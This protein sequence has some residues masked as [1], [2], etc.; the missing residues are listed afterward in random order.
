MDDIANLLKNKKLMITIAAGVGFILVIWIFFYFPARKK[1]QDFKQELQ[2]ITEEIRAIESIDGI[3]HRSVAE[4]LDY[5]Q[6]KYDSIFRRLPS[7]EE[8]A[9]TI[10]SSLAKDMDLE[11][12]SIRPNKRKISANN[13]KDTSYGDDLSCFEVPIFLVMKGQYRAIGEYLEQLRSGDLPILIR[14]NT[15]D[16]R[17]D[18]R[19]D[20]VLRADL[21]IVLYLLC[22]D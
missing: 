22:K 5:L 15:L 13:Q 10:L 21:N 19:N 20:S 12:V 11:V 16:I 18:A 4:M 9:L 6:E 17:K 14:V 3:H 8:D 2:V 7:Q 1:V